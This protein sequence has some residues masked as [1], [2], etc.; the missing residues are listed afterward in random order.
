[1]HSDWDNSDEDYV[2]STEELDANVFHIWGPLQKP[3]TL[4]YTT[5]ELHSECG[6]PFFHSRH[7]TSNFVQ[8]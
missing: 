2:D 7:K 4:Q 8:R 1:M 6:A 3:I 5:E